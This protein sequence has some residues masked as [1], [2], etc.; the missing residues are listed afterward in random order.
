MAVRLFEYPSNIGHQTT[1]PNKH[2]WGWDVLYVGQ[3]YKSDESLFACRF[4]CRFA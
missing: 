1:K 4:A 2:I 3:T